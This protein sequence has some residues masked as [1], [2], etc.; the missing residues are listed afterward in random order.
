LIPETEMCFEK[1]RTGFPKQRGVSSNHTLDSGKQRRVSKNT[2]WIPKAD[3]SVDQPRTGFPKQGRLSSNHEPVFQNK[4]QLA[5]KG[6]IAT[7]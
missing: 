7:D 2:Y 1:T 6:F 5:E 3:V 4:Y